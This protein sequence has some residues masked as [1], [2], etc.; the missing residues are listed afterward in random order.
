[1]KMF[2]NRLQAGSLLAGLLVVS[3]GTTA[4]SGK[5][6]HFESTA[7]ASASVSVGATHATPRSSS[8][9]KA[10]AAP[11]PQVSNVPAKPIEAAAVPQDISRDVADAAFMSVG[12]INGQVAAIYGDS[13]IKVGQTMVVKVISDKA[14]EV[15]IHGYNLAQDVKPGAPAAITFT[16]NIP[17][18][19]D[20][21][22][23][24]SHL[25]LFT[26]TVK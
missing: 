21:E 1:M 17:G 8:G 6:Y 4:C 23:E 12:I 2:A 14:D 11:R 26:L 3:A 7:D 18:R 19:F 15:H 24:H 22:L 20:V 16:A 5:T 9:N 13:T 10:A 25:K